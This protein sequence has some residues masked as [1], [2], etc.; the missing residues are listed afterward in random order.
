MSFQSDLM[1]ALTTVAGGRVY[2][3][4]APEDAVYPFVNYRVASYSPIVTIDGKVHATDYQVVFECWA[5]DY[6]S[7]LSTAE[8]VR[9]AVRAST[10]NY[11]PT[12]QPGEDYEPQADSFCEFVYYEFMH[13]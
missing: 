13:A 8:S 9:V 10:L 3:Q 4:V 1:A 6:A 5:K 11:T 2:P 7:A 12:E